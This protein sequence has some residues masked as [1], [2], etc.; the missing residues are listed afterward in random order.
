MCIYIY[1]YTYTH[2]RG[3]ASLSLPLTSI[4]ACD[5]ER[6]SYTSEPQV[7]GVKFSVGYKA[8]QTATWFQ[9]ISNCSLVETLHTKILE[10]PS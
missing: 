5:R 9:H 3:C 6:G 1:I 8:V 10:P 7:R 2:I 4:S